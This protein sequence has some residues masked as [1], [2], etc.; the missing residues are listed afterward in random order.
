MVL[1]KR[2]KDLTMN[3]ANWRPLQE[4]R[5]EDQLLPAPFGTDYQHAERIAC[6]D[7][8]ALQSVVQC[9]HRNE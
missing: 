3:V 8:A 9:Y 1:L 4:K 5:A 6:F 7:D 2:I